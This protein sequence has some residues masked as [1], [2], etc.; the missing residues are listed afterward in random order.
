MF[1]DLYLCLTDHSNPQYKSEFSENQESP[2]DNVSLFRMN[3]HLKAFVV[4]TE[5]RIKGRFAFEVL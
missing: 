3:P 5:L 1:I 4:V 2:A